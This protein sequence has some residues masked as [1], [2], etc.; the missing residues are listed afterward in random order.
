MASMPDGFVRLR[1]NVGI[2]NGRGGTIGWLAS[3]DALAVV[4]TQL[5][6]TAAK[7]LAGIPQRGDRQIDALINT[8]HHGDHTSG[9]SVFRPVVKKIVAHK[10]VP[11]LQRAAAARA[12]P[13]AL[14]KQVYA[15]T[16]FAETWSLALGGSRDGAE[17]IHARHFGPAHTSGDI[18]VLFEK[19]NIVHMG[20]LVF[21]RLHPV[22]DRAGGASIAG[23]IATL[24]TAAKTYPADA[25]YVFGHGGATPRFGVTGGRDDLLA[26]RDYLTGLLDHTH[27]QIAA[28]KSRAEIITL[29]KL[30]GF[31]EYQ[32]TRRLASNL[33][34]THDEIINAPRA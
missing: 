16:T 10:N 25:I 20:D 17:T 19:A 33:G 21:N 6:D 31:E 4:D 23:W 2:F 3:P 18:I 30:P 13:P 34:V 14:D 28:G 15:D 7:C 29:D 5:P 9:N 8:H 32:Q 27:R 22:I 1:R 11:G 12:K 24:E 26:M